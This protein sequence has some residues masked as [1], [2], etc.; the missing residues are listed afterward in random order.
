MRS[1]WLGPPSRGASGAAAWWSRACR[2]IVPAVFVASAAVAVPA[3]PSTRRRP[4]RSSPSLPRVRRPR[5]SYPQGPGAP[6]CSGRSSAARR[7]GTSSRA[8]ASLASTTSITS[9]DLVY[10]CS[11]GKDAGILSGSR[12]SERGCRSSSST[13]GSISSSP[14]PDPGG[15]G[16]GRSAQA[17]ALSG[18]LRPLRA[19]LSRGGAPPRSGP[20]RSCSPRSPGPSRRGGS[21]CS[22]IAVRSAR[23][24]RSSSSPSSPLPR[25]G[26]PAEPRF[27][28]A[29]ILSLS[30]VGLI[31]TH[32]PSLF[33]LGVSLVP[34]LVVQEG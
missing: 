4:S 12:I 28:T 22:T 18:T 14:C 30:V 8:R 11:L 31:L 9:G 25:C 32:L 20:P 23:R 33:T 2:R 3:G 21:R 13:A 10:G 6:P 29:A 5:S 1:E 16:A 7:P 26:P 24:T 17:G 27:R 15:T 34:A 19:V